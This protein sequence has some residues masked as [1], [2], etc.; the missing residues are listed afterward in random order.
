MV[1]ESSIVRVYQRKKSCWSL[2]LKRI[3]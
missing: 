2:N 3:N 1:K